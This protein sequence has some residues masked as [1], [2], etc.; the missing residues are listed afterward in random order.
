MAATYPT[1]VKTY[2][3]K[4]D[5]VS[6]VLAADINSVQEEVTAIE[7]AVGANPGTTTLGATVGTFTTTPGSSVTARI[8]NLEAG[9]TGDS[10]TGARVGYTQIVPTTALATTNTITVTGSSYVKLVVQITVTTAGSGTQITLTPNGATSSKYY[11]YTYSTGTSAPTGAGNAAG[12]GGIPI[13]MA[14]A[15]TDGYN[16][17][18]ELQNVS[19]LGQKTAT[20]TNNAGWG[21]GTF[22]SGS[23]IA[24]SAI[25]TLVLSCTT[26]PTS[27]TYTVYGVK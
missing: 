17:T 13:T 11:Y 21:N 27:A 19:N 22:V 1:G 18:V 5:G 8:N 7:T 10:T 15:P 25:T 6:V 26:A 23:T 9:L 20:W 16:I 24:S 2:T 14:V 12:S 3:N 4:T